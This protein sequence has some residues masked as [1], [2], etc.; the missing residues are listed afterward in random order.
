MTEIRRTSQR[1]LPG[2]IA[3]G[4]ITVTA[5]VAAPLIATALP[6]GSTK[7]S[8]CTPA[9][10]PTAPSPSPT[11]NP[12]PPPPPPPVERAVVVAATKQMVAFGGSVSF[13]AE[14]TSLDGTCRVGERVE[15]MAQDLGSDSARPV[16]GGT[17]ATDGTVT[18]GTKARASATYWAVAP[19]T[20]DAAEAMSE[21]VTVLSKV[22]MS[23]RT[24][25]PNP[26]RGT[27]FDITAE[28][29]PEHPKSEAVLQRKDGERW[30]KVKKDKANSRSEFTF[31]IKAKWKGLRI[32]RVTWLK[33]HEDHEP[34]N[35]NRVRVRP[36]EPRDDGRGGRGRN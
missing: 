34:S 2:R 32:F 17:T 31:K 12:T 4:A 14:L 6:S 33:Q 13:T 29:R 23:A 16:A 26:E 11:R 5:L 27:K 30:I 28:V 35:S 9:P 10:T 25:S 19:A 21:P 36:V 3:L 1:R 15:I 8:T 24:R 22:S 20:K 7:A 18:V